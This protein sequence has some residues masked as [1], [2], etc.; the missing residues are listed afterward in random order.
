MN[1][2]K[3]YYCYYI[4]TYYKNHSFLGSAIQ[5]YVLGT[6]GV[7]NTVGTG[8]RVVITP[9]PYW[10]TLPKDHPNGERPV[11]IVD[12]STTFLKFEEALKIME[13]E[14]TVLILMDNKFDVFTSH[15]ITKRLPEGSYILHHEFHQDNHGAFKFVKDETYNSKT[16]KLVKKTKTK[17]LIGDWLSTAGYEATAVIF[18]SLDTTTRANSLYGMDDHRYATY[19][20]RAKAKLVIYRAPNAG[21][22][23]KGSIDSFQKSIKSQRQ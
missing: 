18:I 17:F 22:Y 11:K 15:N 3:G 13:N 2:S 5:N 9:V 7:G 1:F 20:Q 23:S 8:G 10:L 21:F 14:A 6:G 19:C 12:K 16:K 4:S